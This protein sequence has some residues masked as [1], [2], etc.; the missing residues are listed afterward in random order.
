MITVKQALIEAKNQ[1]STT[2]PHDEAQR[3]ARYLLAE[4]LGVSNAWLIGHMDETLPTESYPKFSQRVLRRMEGEP[5]AYILGYREF[6]GL[7]LHITPDTLIP[8]PDTETLVEAAFEYLPMDADMK[9]VDLG[10]GSGAIAL[11][12]A[13]HRPNAQV[14]AVDASEAALRVAQEN[15][16]R[17]NLS[18]V[19]SINS[20]WFSE[21]DH[22]Q[23]DLIVSNPPYIAENDHHLH[24]GDVRFEPQSALISGLDGLDDI[25]HIVAKATLHLRPAGWLMLEHGYDQSSAVASLMKSYGYQEISH[26][27]DLSGIARVTLGQFFA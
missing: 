10:T 18:N 3:E 17:L 25:R 11:A 7:R 24:Q 9:V 26:R 8:R 2:L 21:L 5:V 27:Y 19:Y 1:L 6:F 14:F 22:R 15:I 23:F 12:I 20:H 16:R 4:T 13:H